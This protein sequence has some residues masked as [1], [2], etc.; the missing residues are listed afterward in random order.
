MV[1]SSVEKAGVLV[2]RDGTMIRDVGYLTRVDEIEILPGVPEAIRLLS[3]RGLKVAVITN[4][5]AVGRGLLKEEELCRIH[6]EL[7]RRLA[8][9]DAR[10]DG[11]YY[12]PHHPTEASGS[13]RVACDC[14]KPNVG[15][16][17]RAAAELRL[18]LGRSYVVGDQATDME[19]AARIGA[20]GIFIQG[21]QPESAAP[22]CLAVKGL[23]E[24]ANWIVRDFA[25][26]K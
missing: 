18:D 19:L 17:E 2:D 3:A 11:V 15:L 14:R 22:G 6:R 16:A 24:A 9:S 21:R 12:C 8:A 13:Y 26:E 20:R 5:S 25:G 10:V 7:E 23:W 1:S 4:Q